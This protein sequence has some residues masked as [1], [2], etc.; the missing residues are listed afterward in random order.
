[1]P[2]SR[3]NGA[4]PT[5]VA[6]CWRVNVPSSG[7]SA[8]Q[9]VF[10]R[11]RAGWPGA[12]GPSRRPRGQLPLQPAHVDLDPPPHPGQ[13]RP[14]QPVPLGG[15]LLDELGGSGSGR[16]AGCTAAEVG[17][18][19]RVEGRSWRVDR[20]L[21]RSPAPVH[22]HGQ[23]RGPERARN[24]PGRWL[25]AQS[26]AAGAGV[27]AAAWSPPRVIGH[28]PPCAGASA[29][30]TATTRVAWATSMDIHR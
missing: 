20:W 12:P 16:G 21:W 4:T 19:L 15:H 3:F 1:M 25:R 29:G 9:Q 23:A 10:L 11:A 5:K 13:G 30:R 28:G 26:G 17:Q 14:G 27:G 7:S 8:L 6:T 24:A 18:H 22:R 2:L